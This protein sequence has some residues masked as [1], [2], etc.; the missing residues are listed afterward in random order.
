MPPNPPPIHPEGPFRC[1]QREA[2]RPPRESLL[3]RPAPLTVKPGRTLEN[4]RAYESFLREE[5]IV[6]KRRWKRHSRQTLAWVLACASL[7][8]LILVLDFI[9]F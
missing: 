1:F 4:P 5:T 2:Q 6:R 9:F 7:P 8:V 3:A